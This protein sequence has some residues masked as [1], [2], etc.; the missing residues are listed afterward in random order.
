VSVRSDGRFQAGSDGVLSLAAQHI[1][2]FVEAE[3]SK[4]VTEK[5]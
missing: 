3:T 4:Y 5:T 2:R 1:P